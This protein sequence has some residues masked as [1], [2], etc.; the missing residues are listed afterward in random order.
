MTTRNILSALMIVL[1][2]IYFTSC[3]PLEQNRPD[4]SQKQET[5]DP[6]TGKPDGDDKEE[7]KE[8]VGQ[9]IDSGYGYGLHPGNGIRNNF[10]M[11]RKE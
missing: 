6:D 4:D 10:L 7:D 1:A 9:I 2:G 5:T 11:V 8:E 3:D